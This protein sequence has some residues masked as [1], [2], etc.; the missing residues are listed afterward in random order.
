MKA[1]DII[2]GWPRGRSTTTAFYNGVWKTVDA[3][4]YWL[5]FSVAMIEQWKMDAEYHRAQQKM[6]DKHLYEPMLRALEV[7]ELAEARL[8]RMPHVRHLPRQWGNPEGIEVVT[9][10]RLSYKYVNF[11]IDQSM[12]PS[13]VFKKLHHVVDSDG[14]GS[15]FLLNSKLF[16]EPWGG[17]R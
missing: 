8:K 9:L 17:I 11:M 14:T 1:R 3:W 15:T 12:K 7:V 4:P 6:V 16:E 5:R 10:L 13:P 2:P